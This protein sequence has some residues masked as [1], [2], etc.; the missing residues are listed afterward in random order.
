M[1]ETLQKLR[2][3][4]DLLCYFLRPSAIAAMSQASATGFVV[5]G[6]WRQQFDWAVIEWNRDN[7]FEHPLLRNLPDGDLSGI[8]LSYEETRENCIPLDSNL[9]HTVD[10]PSLRAWK[11]GE[12]EPFFVPL[13]DHAEAIEG[14]FSPATAVFTL[15]G[16]PT[17][18]DYVEVAWLSEH[19]T[20]QFFAESD[21]LAYAVGIIADA[22]NSGSPTMAASASGA[23]LT[24]TYLGESS[25]PGIRESEENSKTGAN[26]NR[27]GAYANVQGAHTESWS[28]GWVYFSGG[29][30]P[31][32]WRFTLNFAS[33]SYYTQS[34]ALVEDNPS[35]AIRKLRWTYAADFQVGEYVR[36]EFQVTVSNWSVTG[37]GLGYQVAGPQSRRVD[38]ISPDLVYTGM[39]HPAVPPGNFSGGLLHYTTD[40]AA[41]VS[42][43]YTA[44]QNHRLYLGTRKSFNGTSVTIVVDGGSPR[45]ENLLI[46]GEDVL[47]RILLGDLAGG[48]PHSVTVT[49]ADAD[50]NYFY[51][52][53][54]EIAVPATDLPEIEPD[55]QVTLATDWDTDHSIALPAERT[56]WLI[57]TLGFTGRANHYV[58]ALWFYELVRLGHS[59]AS[60]IVTFSGTPLFE[61]GGATEVDIVLSGSTT[62]LHHTHL[63]G[64]TATSVAKAFELT[65]NNGFTA[66]RAQST[67][68]V[69]TIFARA[70]GAQGNDILFAARVLPSDQTSFHADAS[71]EHL[72]GGTDGLWRTDLTAAPRINRAARDWG[73]SYC[74]AMKSYGI[75]VTAAFSLELQ[76]GNTDV[77]AGIAQR[78]SD[79]EPVQLNTPALQTNFSPTSAAFWQQ[80]Y[81]DMANVMA[82]AEC[83]PYLQFGEAQWWYFVQDQ[84]WALNIPRTHDSLPFYDA[85][86]TSTFEATYGRAMHVFANSSESTASFP[87]E[88]A[89]LPGLIGAFT[90]QMISFVGATHS[91]AKFEVLYPPDVN[92]STLNRVINLPSEWTPET[93]ECL[94]TENF[95]F[96]GGRNLNQARGSI[97]LP[98]ELGFPAAKASHLVGIGDYTSPW[99]REVRASKAEGVESVV[100]FALDQFCLIGYPA[101]LERSQ[102]R[103]VFMAE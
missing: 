76:H 7:T 64:D 49:H 71:G 66:V 93:L 62:T 36:S 22:I 46:P 80:V 28:P 31:T 101:P 11:E 35:S 13:K 87:E 73:R 3:D 84:D 82:E 67:G 61:S 30:S 68:A 29:T 56:A 74:A 26:G 32:K 54:F 16:T 55:P 60:G 59:Y 20:Y 12:A 17:V 48:A 83:V 95:L 47:V 79:G 18:G 81:L 10:W 23:Q 44:A 52:D 89:F 24:L 25:T 92:D 42:Y 4:R 50:S 1:P 69:L 34:G 96:T 14:A 77:S 85:Y 103:S 53:F 86:T 33:M 91:N 15:T 98:M 94:K 41:S 102:R 58:G 51:F 45:T 9:F 90:G 19:Y 43:T 97:T 63:A 39:W 88:A 99:L 100:L 2:P 57:K 78:Y 38:D 75:D 8:V 72:A 5:S 37:A 40:H 6:T 70:M 21:T 27:L 65:I